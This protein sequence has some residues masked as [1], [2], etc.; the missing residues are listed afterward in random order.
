[1]FIC[2]TCD[3]RVAVLNND[4]GYCP[5]CNSEL[6]QQPDNLWDNQISISLDFT[7]VKCEC[8]N[9]NSYIDSFCSKCGEKCEPQPDSVDPKVKYRE[10][11]FSCILDFI[12][13]SEIKI[14]E[15]RRNIHKGLVQT[16]FSDDFISSAQYIIERINDL[17]E[18]KIFYN[19]SFNSYEMESE[20]TDSKISEIQQYIIDVYGTY[21]EFLTTEYPYAWKNAY[22]RLLK[23]LQAFLDSTK[24]VIVSIVSLTFKDALENMKLAEQ[25]LNTASEDISIFSNILHTNDL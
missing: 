21:E 4:I 25:K 15:L 14:K 19:I 1:M 6:I 24:L 9:I 16:K 7:I 18:K 17:L 11:K 10:E 20:E 23:T 8:G 13:L 12:K 3:N 5:V 2:P 22:N